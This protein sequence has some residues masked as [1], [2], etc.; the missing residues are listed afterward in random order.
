MA[1]DTALGGDIQGSRQV[2]CCWMVKSLTI[3]RPSASERLRNKVRVQRLGKVISLAL[4]LKKK[5]P[6]TS[7]KM[8]E[9]L[10]F[11]DFLTPSKEIV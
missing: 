1:L 4:G 2:N 10:I 5:F 3:G 6:R 11:N 8:V 7:D 9:L